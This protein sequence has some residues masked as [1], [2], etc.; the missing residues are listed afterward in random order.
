MNQISNRPVFF[1]FTMILAFLLSVTGL[2]F[3]RTSAQVDVA[4]ERTTAQQTIAT[5]PAIRQPSDTDEDQP[6]SD[7]PAIQGIRTQFAGRWADPFEGRKA[8]LQQTDCRPDDSELRYLQCYLHDLAITKQNPLTIMPVQVES[9][10][11]SSQVQSRL[12]TRHAVEYALAAAG[13]EM[14]YENRM[15]FAKPVW[16]IHFSNRDL[17]VRSEIPIKLYSRSQGSA[18]GSESS[19]PEHLLVCWIDS[20]QQGTRRIQALQSMLQN[21]VGDAVLKRSPIRFIGPNYSAELA[22]IQREISNTAPANETYPF[23]DLDFKVICPSAT[24]PPPDLTQIRKKDDLRILIA[25]DQLLATSLVQELIQRRRH[26]GEILIVSQASGVSPDGLKGHVLKQLATQIPG[27]SKTPTFAQLTYLKDIAGDQ[28]NSSNLG[29][30]ERLSDYFQ[31]QLRHISQTGGLQSEDVSAIFVIGDEPADKLAIIEALKPIFVNA[32]FFTHDLHQSFYSQQAIPFTRGLVV[33]SRGVLTA[34]SDPQTTGNS[35]GIVFRDCYQKSSYHAVLT[36]ISAQENTKLDVEEVTLFEIGFG[37]PISLSEPL[38]GT[39]L[40]RLCGMLVGLLLTLGVLISVRSD[41]GSL[42]MVPH[43]GEY[44]WQFWAEMYRVIQFLSPFDPLP[45]QTP[46]DSNLELYGIP[47]KRFDLFAVLFEFR[48]E[49]SLA[50]LASSTLWKDTLHD[51]HHQ[52]IAALFYVVFFILT[53]LVTVRSLLAGWRSPSPSPQ[54]PTEDSHSSENRGS[55]NHARIGTPSEQRLFCFW[56]LSFLILCLYFFIADSQRNLVMIQEPLLLT[57]GISS[58]TVLPG[59]ILVDIVLIVWLWNTWRRPCHVS[60]DRAI[61]NCNRSTDVSKKQHET[62][63]CFPH[64]P[65]LIAKYSDKQSSPES[66]SNAATEKAAPKAVVPEKVPKNKAARDKGDHGKGNDVKDKALDKIED[67]LQVAVRVAVFGLLLLFCF[68]QAHFSRLGLINWAL[69]PLPPTRGALL[70]FAI[71]FLSSLGLLL[72]LNTCL[73]GLIQVRLLLAFI[74]CMQ[75]RLEHPTDPDQGKSQVNTGNTGETSQGTRPPVAAVQVRDACD[76]IQYATGDTTRHSLRD[77][78]LLLLA[79][80]VCRLPVLESW[81]ASANTMLLLAG[82]P[83]GI[84]IFLALKLRFASNAFRQSTL[85]YL[86]SITSQAPDDLQAISKRA[87]E[88]GAMNGGAFSNL[89]SDPILGTVLVVATALGS[90]QS[91]NPITFLFGFVP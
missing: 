27:G 82:I 85:R 32:G 81:V 17:Y 22:E 63:F 73:S 31:Q 3:P 86:H 72:T 5:A 54:A 45:P 61:Q 23:K 84:A 70:Q 11:L 8:T 43:I 2:R 51:V 55:S 21:L 56:L 34:T 46:T 35:P 90:S 68:Y 71:M 53:F 66:N 18:E 74:K 15:S 79:F 49:L 39:Y 89:V 16:K 6:V 80:S 62:A 24:S 36:A 60:A 77:P 52:T 1:N 25:S 10:S 29:P 7:F 44:L 14:T 57:S 28:K 48:A 9:G 26:Y 64:L 30:K 59:L 76:F 38:R 42:L 47:Q 41:H 12:N 67:K 33:A 88:I 13:Y 58:W 37:G 19:R 69:F 50:G 87:D 91:F 78:A 75:Q 40:L 20:Q 65:D 4:T 83:T